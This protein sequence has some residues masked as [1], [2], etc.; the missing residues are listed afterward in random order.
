[1]ISV[2]LP[3]FNRLD[4]L[5]AN[6]ESLRALAGVGEIVVVVDG[7]TDGTAAWLAQIADDRVRIVEQENRGS[8][9]ARNRGVAEARGDWLL[10]VEDD[11]FLLAD[12]VTTLLDVAQADGA[13][14]VGA[15][16]VQVEDREHIECELAQRR[17]RAKDR[18]RLTTSHMV[19]P[20]RDLETPFLN[21]IVL[22][23]RDVFD[24]VR[25]DESLVGN[26]WREETSLF[27]SAVGAGFKC[28]LTPRTASLQLGQWD[29]GQR[30]PRLSYELSAMRN[31]WR[32][33]RRHR[34]ALR[35]LG[36]VHDPISGQ[37]AFVAARVREVGGGYV[38]AR[39]ERRRE[40]AA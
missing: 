16:W 28:V 22:V 12:F 39:R 37:L 5:R 8:P 15:P 36:E 26:A 2:V 29:G 31:N 7:S 30:R 14:I 35:E 13:Q 21:G 17:E 25:Y 23:R 1:M 6:F 11:C 38:R 24:S 20:D 40:P 10:M 32:F 27:L 9:A 19:F 3:T 18:I 4:A 34:R 33:L